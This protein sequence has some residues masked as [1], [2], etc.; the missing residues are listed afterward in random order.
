MPKSWPMSTARSTLRE[1]QLQLRRAVLGGDSPELVATIRGDG[2]APAARLEIYRN[3]AFITLGAVLE[4]KFPVVC[5]LVDKRFFAYAAHEYLR[6]HPPHSR[7]LVEYGADFAD[8]L[9]GFEPCRG[10]P[11][12]ADVARFEWALDIAVTLREAAPLPIGALAAAAAGRAACLVLRLQASASYFA[13]CWPIDAIWQAN[14]ASEVPAVDLASG[15]TCIEIGRAGDAVTWRR[16]DPG[17][18]AFRRA[19]A[20]GLALDAAAATA[21]A[22]DAA[23]DLAAALKLVFAEGL[24]IGF[25]NSPE[26]ET[27]G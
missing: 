16:L 18:F 12:L 4:G 6:A 23:F 3:H 11:Y 14:Q 2:L 27:L 8:F 13:S 10:L 9:A 17:T 20:A 1:L 24:A 19:L 7:C 26:E 15:A 25:G 5:R 22:N 21:T